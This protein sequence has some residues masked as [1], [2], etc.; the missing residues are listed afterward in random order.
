MTQLPKSIIVIDDDP[1]VRDVVASSLRIYGK[2]QVHEATDGDEGLSL[3]LEHAPDLAI[4]DVSMPRMNGYQVVRALR[5]DP[6]T[7]QMPII[8]LTARTM[9]RD[10]M[11]GLYSGADLYLEK[12]VRPLQLIEAIAQVLRRSQEDRIA[13]MRAYVED[14]LPIEESL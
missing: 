2:F 14:P 7:C 4:V 12:P 5:G 10:R 11:T 9:P 8:M 1:Y 13:T 3:C 6:T